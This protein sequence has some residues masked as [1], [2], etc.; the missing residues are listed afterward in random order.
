MNEHDNCSELIRDLN[1]YIDGE[2]SQTVCSEIERHM[3]DCEDC[4]VFYDTT[5]KVIY[6][7]RNQQEQ[8]DLP[9]GARQRL[10]R[11]LDLEDFLSDPE[12]P[13]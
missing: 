1:D 2:A 5:Q 7:Y 12:S 3:A 13:R 11:A 8:K 10:F 6:L 4:K 9:A